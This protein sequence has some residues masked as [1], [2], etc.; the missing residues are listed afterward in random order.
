MPLLAYF[1]HH[2]CASSWINQILMKVC[3]KTDLK[4]GFANSEKD[5]KDF[6]NINNIEFLS[7]IN[8]IYSS[9]VQLDLTRAFHVI[10]DPHDIVVSAYFSHFYS[11]PVFEDWPELVDIRKKLYSISKEEGLFFEMEENSWIFEILDE[12]NY[13]HPDILEIKMESLTQQPYEIFL[14]ILKFLDL[15]AENHEDSHTMTP[16]ELKRILDE[17][18]FSKLSGGRKRGEE[19][20]DHHYRKGVSG[21]WRN[22]F[23]KEH[24]IAF[25]KKYGRL[26]ITLGYEKDDNWGS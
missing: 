1:G 7:D 20:S 23:K 3:E 16:P 5:L 14:T 26:L 6:V 2:K 15:L 18:S 24:E 8:A 4:Q 13:T 9:V 11:H 25:K 21:D 10:R 22:H 17:V 12:W 19:N